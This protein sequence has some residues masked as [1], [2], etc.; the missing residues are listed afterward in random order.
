M[1]VN[2]Y[3]VNTGKKQRV[4]ESHLRRFPDVLSL[5]PKAKSRKRS[6]AKQAPQ[7]DVQDAAVEQETPPTKAP[8]AGD[9][10]E[11]VTTHA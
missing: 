4:P 11:G 7:N 3:N 5:T 9:E 1:F 10:S 2:A 8:T 6:S